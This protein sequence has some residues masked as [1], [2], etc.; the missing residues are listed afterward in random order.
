MRFTAFLIGAASAANPDPCT[1]LCNLDGPA[2][3]IGGSWTKN[4]VCHS[5]VF[6]GDPAVGDYCYHTKATAPRCPGNGKP[7]KVSDAEA[8]LARAGGMRG[9]PGPAGDDVVPSPHA[10]VTTTIDPAMGH[11]VAD[12]ERGLTAELYEMM[13]EVWTTMGEALEPASTSGTTTEAPSAATIHEESLTHR[14]T[15]LIRRTF[16]R[17]PGGSIRFKVN[18]DNALEESLDFLNGPVMNLL[19]PDLFASFTNE[20][21]NGVEITKAWIVEVTKQ[22]FDPKAGFFTMTAE[23]PYYYSINPTGYSRPR[24]REI[25][26]AVGRL[27]GLSI[28]RNQPL[29]VNLSLYIFAGI[30]GQELTFDDIRREEPRLVAT[31]DMLLACKSN[32]DLFGFFITIGDVKRRVTLEN[33]HALIIQKLYSI[34]NVSEQPAFRDIF[35]GIVDVFP[36]LEQRD[37]FPRM[38]SLLS[39]ADFKE[40]ILGNAEVDVD[41][42]MANAKMELST[43]QREMLHRVL[44]SFTA[45]ERKK[46]LKFATNLEQV[47]TGGFAALERPIYL[48]SD[49]RPDPKFR[50][51]P[52]AILRD[53]LV[54]IPLYEN[55]AEMKERLLQAIKIGHRGWV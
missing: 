1:A 46:F 16:E 49:L 25:Y 31:M 23:A 35:E 17:I 29:G 6:R 15:E 44:R 54:V 8:I 50:N 37:R 33:R 55:D 51:L 41:D 42:L 26:K 3:C 40:L 27:L 12:V 48:R 2:V 10:T 43:P 47:P 7:V 30:L 20:P 9:R 4:G 53:N 11:D 5:Y 34:V 32:R 19:V 21:G 38:I 36:W 18:R 22:V 52:R 14:V 45:E 24:A 28:I 13:K 39:A